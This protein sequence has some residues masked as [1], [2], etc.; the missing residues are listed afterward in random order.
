MENHK[1]RLNR[2]EQIS[3]FKKTI[4]VQYLSEQKWITRDEEDEW[5]SSKSSKELV[6]S[7][8]ASENGQPLPRILEWEDV[9]CARKIMT[10]QNLAG[11]LSV[12]FEDE[13]P[14]YPEKRFIQIQHP[15]TEQWCLID[16]N[17]ARIT[18][19]RENHFDDIPKINLKINKKKY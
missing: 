10:E 8:D 2:I 17:I 3:G 6:D 5:L 4:S 16:R 18:E 12:L 13:K 9:N 15:N 19:R 14:E 11:T 1:K 7:M